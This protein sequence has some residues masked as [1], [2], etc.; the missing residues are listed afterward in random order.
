ML[1]NTTN[2]FYRV[3]LNNRRERE[4]ERETEC[5]CVCVYTISYGPRGLANEKVQMICELY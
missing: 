1:T 2:Y 4:R 5:V 3:T